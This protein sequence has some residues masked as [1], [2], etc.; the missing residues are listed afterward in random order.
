MIISR[1][2]KHVEDILLYTE[3]SKYNLRGFFLNFDTKF[4]LVNEHEEICSLTRV[5]T[6]MTISSN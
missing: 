3:W 6:K 2:V 4:T 5:T 1:H